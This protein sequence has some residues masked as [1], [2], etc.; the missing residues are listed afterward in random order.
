M[1]LV[2]AGGIVDGASMA[3]ALSRG[4]E[5]VWCGTRFL[6]SH[7]A[8]AHEGYQARLVQAGH[9]CTTISTVFGPEWPG[10]PLRALVNDAVRT[11]EGR[12]DAALAEANGLFIGTTM[13]GGVAVP[14]PRYSA[15]LPTRAFNGDLEWSCLTAGECAAMIKS[16]EPASAIIDQ[17]MEEARRAS[18]C[19]AAG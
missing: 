10:Q 7:E 17:M 8:D 6:A 4:A 2:A 16:I 3:A 11:S 12:I 9:G 14:V 1:P 18:P 5:A 19:T 13:L 15:L